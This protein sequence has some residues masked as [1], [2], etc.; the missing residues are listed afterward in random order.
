MKYRVYG[1]DE[2]G[3]SVSDV[4]YTVN[5]GISKELAP[6]FPANFI[7]ETT[8]T[9]LAGPGQ[10]GR[11]CPQPTRPTTAWWRW[12]Q[13]ASGAGRRTMPPPRGR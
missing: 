5:V 9:E 6:Q 10:R 12:T 11:L 4:P 8:A 7:A 13:R 3:F 2:K 1:S